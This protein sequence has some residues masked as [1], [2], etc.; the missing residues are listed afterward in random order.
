MDLIK[1]GA[2]DANAVRKQA[3]EEHNKER[4]TKAVKAIKALLV[5]RDKAQAV[6][7]NIDAQIADLERRIAE[8]TFRE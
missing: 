2:I 6:L 8:G 1:G 4:S 5:D 3:E 7:A